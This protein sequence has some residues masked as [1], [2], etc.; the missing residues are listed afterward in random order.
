MNK[1][2]KLFVNLKKNSPESLYPLAELRI[3]DALFL[4]KNYAEAIVQYEDFKK[5]HPLHPGSLTLFIKLE[6]PTLNNCIVWI[7]TKA[8]RKKRSN[9][10]GI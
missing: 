4:D 2:R 8:R 6:C 7:A 5:L 10:F 1:L 3:A 9:N